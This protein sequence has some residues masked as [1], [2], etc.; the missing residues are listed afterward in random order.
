MIK[1]LYITL[2]LIFKGEC[3]VETDGL[4]QDGSDVTQSAEEPVFWRC[5][6]PPATRYDDEKQDLHSV[7]TE[8]LCLETPPR[9]T[10]CVAE[11]KRSHDYLDLA[12]A[13]LHPHAEL[14]RSSEVEK[15]QPETEEE[16][17]EPTGS[18]CDAS[19]EVRE[20]KAASE[21]GEVDGEMR[22]E[23]N[24]NPEVLV[25]DSDSLVEQNQTVE[26]KQAPEEQKFLLNNSE[27]VSLK[28]ESPDEEIQT[29]RECETMKEEAEREER[30]VTDQSEERGTR[31]TD[32]EAA[33]ETDQ[34]EHQSEKEVKI[35]EEKVTKTS[36][37]VTFA[38]PEVENSK[39]EF[40]NG[41]TVG[42]KSDPDHTEMN[43]T[44]HQNINT[45]SAPP[46]STETDR[47]CPPPPLSPTAEGVSPSS[48]IL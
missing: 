26:I 1:N 23:D 6:Q 4:V 15:Q 31:G 36:K 8:A 16:H 33:E 2:Y 20:E 44:L 17:E 19:E 32:K 25:E 9:R 3:C 27:Q 22:N 39:S 29:E 18:K 48:S 46:T 10:N 12:R 47:Q 35:L 30:T 7:L 11:E 5:L 13:D 43:G 24:A 41:G 34:V 42:N 28:A 37:Q 40:V 45:H 14:S 38:G 21:S